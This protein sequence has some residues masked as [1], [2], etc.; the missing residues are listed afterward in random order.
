MANDRYVNES[1]VATRHAIAMHRAQ[2]RHGERTIPDFEAL[3]SYPPK[4]A[5]KA[6]YKCICFVFWPHLDCFEDLY[7]ALGFEIDFP[8]V[9]YDGL[10]AIQYSSAL[11]PSSTTYN[12]TKAST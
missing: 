9:H 12:P 8:S 4:M 10:Y 7:K 2:T 6:F 1:A 11:K 5:L 3:Y